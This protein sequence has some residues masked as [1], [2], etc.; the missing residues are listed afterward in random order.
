MDQRLQ[1]QLP[2]DENQETGPPIV[3]TLPLHIPEFAE[4]VRSFCQRIKEELEA[5]DVAF[6]NRD[7]ET[8]ARLAHWLK[9]SGGTVGFNQFTLPATHL[10]TSAKQENTLEAETA[11]A[12]IREMAGRMQVP[13]LESELVET[14]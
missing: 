6:T 14:N 8:L 13:V 7:F 2:D 3:S 1:D 11:L 12:Q 10:E 9:G 5:M 4:I